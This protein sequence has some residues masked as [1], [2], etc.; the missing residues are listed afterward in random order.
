MGCDWA[1]PTVPSDC[2]NVF[3]GI[4]ALPAWY[5]STELV[6]TCDTAT[7]SSSCYIVLESGEQSVA[8]PIGLPAFSANPI[9]ASS[10]SGDWCSLGTSRAVW[11]AGGKYLKWKARVYL[12]ALQCDAA[13]SGTDLN[14]II[15]IAQVLLDGDVVW[16]RSYYSVS[17]AATAAKCSCFGGDY[18]TAG[19]SW[20]VQCDG[21]DCDDWPLALTAYH[22]GVKWP[23]YGGSISSSGFSWSSSRSDPCCEDL[24]SSYYYYGCN[25]ATPA[26]VS[27]PDCDEPGPCGATDPNHLL[28]LG[29]P[30]PPD[31]DGVG[32]SDSYHLGV[33]YNDPLCAGDWCMMESLGFTTSGIPGFTDVS[34]SSIT[35]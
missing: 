9:G 16:A 28:T 23:V 27:C 32:V 6:L 5:E 19:T 35:V 7:T 14:T 3:R 26:T 12:R 11:G 31:E 30:D 25:D 20:V 33:D 22:G 17:D 2:D 15:A 10:A 13:G 29:I 8:V 1:G 21:A 24:S 4:G 34:L 18:G